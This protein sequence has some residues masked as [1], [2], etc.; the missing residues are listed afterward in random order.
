ME[1]D[2]LIIGMYNGLLAGVYS[3]NPTLVD[4]RLYENDDQ[5][6]SDRVKEFW[7]NQLLVEWG[8]VSDICEESA[9]EKSKPL[10]QRM[11]ENQN[12]DFLRLFADNPVAKP[13]LHFL[14]GFLCTWAAV[15]QK[16]TALCRSADCGERSKGK[17]LYGVF[18]P[19]LQSWLQT[20]D[21]L[22]DDL[23]QYAEIEEDD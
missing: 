15:N 4:V 9:E 7:R 19:T 18:K 14:E 8:C 23:W 16:I 2:E 1:K 10:F 20:Y 11:D 12:G 17:E 6:D 21:K 13:K 22:F 5:M 3:L